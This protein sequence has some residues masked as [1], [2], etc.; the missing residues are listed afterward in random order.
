MD[1]T[2]DSDNEDDGVDLSLNQVMS[3]VS[4]GEGGETESVASASYRIPKK[5]VM[6]S[7]AAMMKDIKEIALMTAS[8]AAVG[9]SNKRKKDD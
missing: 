2:F 9:V 3:S 6:H 4:D 7:V 5:S 8:N 1:I